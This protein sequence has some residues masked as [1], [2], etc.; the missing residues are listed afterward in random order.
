M[1]ARA[2]AR[3]QEA[4]YFRVQ[5]K[6]NS[7]L[8]N[9]RRRRRRRRRCHRCHRCGEGDNDNECDGRGCVVVVVEGGER[10]KAVRVRPK[11]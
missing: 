1:R 11:T 9:L 5:I 10:L 2:C 3:V 7:Q 4:A 8:E 6:S